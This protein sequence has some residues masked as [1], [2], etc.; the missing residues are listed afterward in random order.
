MPGGPERS[1]G[2]QID[3]SYGIEPVARKWR[4]G[5]DNRSCHNARISPFW[6]YSISFFQFKRCHDLPGYNHN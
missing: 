1:G 5:P 3:D 6:S 4:E 2:E